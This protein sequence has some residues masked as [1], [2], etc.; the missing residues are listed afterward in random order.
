MVLEGLL[1]DSRTA[2]CMQLPRDHMHQK[3]HCYRVYI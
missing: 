3:E 2:V 1:T